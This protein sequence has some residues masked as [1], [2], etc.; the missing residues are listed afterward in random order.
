MGMSSDDGTSDTTTVYS[1]LELVKEKI[2]DKKYDEALE[3]L[4]KSEALVEKMRRQLTLRDPAVADL[5]EQ[6]HLFKE[7]LQKVNGGKI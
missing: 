2:Y 7:A 4:K 5:F 6:V 3:N 1:L